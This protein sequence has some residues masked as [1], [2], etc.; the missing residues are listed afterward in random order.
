MITYFCLGSTHLLDYSVTVDSVNRVGY[1][2][3]SKI[4]VKKNVQLSSYFTL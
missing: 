3:D 2:D 1:R 4:L